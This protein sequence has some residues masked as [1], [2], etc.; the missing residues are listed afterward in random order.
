MDSRKKDMDEGSA[1]CPHCGHAMADEGREV[2]M[3]GVKGGM[4]SFVKAAKKIGGVASAVKKA[5][6]DYD[7]DGKIETGPEEHA[8]SVD[9]A[10]KANKAKPAAKS[11]DKPKAKPAKQTK[12]G[13]K[14]DFLDVDKDGDKKE[15]MKK[16]AKEKKVDETITSGSVATAPAKKSSGGNG[17][18]QGIYDSWE[19]KY[20]SL[21]KED[22]NVTTSS[23]KSDDGEEQENIT[24]NVTGDDVARIKEMLHSMGVSH[25]GD[26]AGHEHGGEEECDSCG[27]VPCQC[28]E[29]DEAKQHDP[30]Y[31]QDDDYDGNVDDIDDGPQDHYNSDERT[32]SDQFEDDMDESAAPF[33]I[34]DKVIHRSQSGRRVRGVFKGMKD[35]VSALIYSH[36]YTHAIPLSNVQPDRGENDGDLYDPKL[37]NPTM[38]DDMDE[39]TSFKD[40]GATIGRIGGTIAGGLGG[41]AAGLGIGT[42]PGAIAGGIAGGSAGSALGTAAGRFLDRKTGAPEETDEDMSGHQRM[43]ELAGLG[44]TSITVSDNEPDYPSNQEYAD[45]RM[46]TRGYAGGGG[47]NEKSTGQATLPVVASQVNR[48]HSHVSE[49]QRMNDLYKAIAAIEDK[50]V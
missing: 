16:A 38:E 5:K 13:A 25:G 46:I 31:E 22:V 40:A 28:D 11:A 48:L 2:D 4:G 36:P 49:G 42:V 9:K 43:M 35:G 17:V 50:E 41:A 7:G 39:E 29:M 30:D 45:T 8:G 27:G 21:L 24:I 10:I 44:E 33:E 18:G 34:G 23:N 19:R 6:K 26:E 1:T 37:P 32:R 15:P 14:P 20:E 3:E 12:E 47:A